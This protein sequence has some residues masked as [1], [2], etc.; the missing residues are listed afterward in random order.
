MRVQLVAATR[1]F[2]GSTN[3]LITLIIWN[4]PEYLHAELLRHKRLVFNWQ[5]HRTASYDTDVEY[6]MPPVFL[7]RRRGM[8]AGPE[9]EE[10]VARQARILWRDA[11]RAAIDGSHALAE[12]GVANE[13][14]RRV[15]P[16]C[17]TMNGVITG[18]E[19][20]WAKVLELR[21]HAAA[22]SAMQLLAKDI[23]HMIAS[24]PF[25]VGN[26][27]R[28]F[29]TDELEGTPDWPYA[30]AARIARVSWGEPKSNEKDVDLGKRLRNSTPPH[31][32][33][34]EHLA[35]AAYDGETVTENR[36]DAW[37]SPIRPSALCSKPA[38][39]QMG[40]GWVNYRAKW[41]MED[42]DDNRGDGNL[43]GGARWN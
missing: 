21:N 36:W 37:H 28:P 10:E 27:H 33:P 32:S 43:I 42:D 5:S 9:L 11:A 40:L 2:A 3:G 24:A 4:C 17:H 41:E 18:T 31:W 30:L 34:F 22:D 23:Q 19:D 7:G 16:S 12:L 14:C 13:Q 15:L 35:E 6:Y 1:L 8:Q 25:T 38:D 26:W 29:W 39:I 20:A